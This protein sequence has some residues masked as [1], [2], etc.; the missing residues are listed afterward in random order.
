MPYMNSM[1]FRMH[2]LKLLEEAL[3]VGD[4]KTAA[5]ATQIAA[6]AHPDAIP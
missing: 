3:I 5:A 6:Q 1:E 4:W 2:D